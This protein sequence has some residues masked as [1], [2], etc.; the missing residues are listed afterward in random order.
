ML[1]EK[2]FNEINLPAIE[3]KGDMAEITVKQFDYIKSLVLGLEGVG[4]K[5]SITNFNVNCAK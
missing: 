3:I 4:F 2:Q 1:S 5:V